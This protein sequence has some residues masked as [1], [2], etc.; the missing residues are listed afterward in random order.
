MA[1][2]K[3]YKC[4]ICGKTFVVDE[5]DREFMNILTGEVD[6]ESRESK[7]YNDICPDCYNAIKK[8]IDDPDI[9][10][11]MYN[12]IQ[13]KFDHENEHLEKM[14]IKASNRLDI[15]MVI[16]NRIKTVMDN[17]GCWRHVSIWNWDEN[18]KDIICSWINEIENKYTE[19]EMSCR[20][21]RTASIILSSI[22]V[23]L[24]ISII[25]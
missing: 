8:V 14:A 19:M 16:E 5:N 10:Q 1:E 18:A 20:G 7:A 17:L 9:I 3:T 11:K 4:D 13:A 25:I 21:W 24:M 2:V 23:G 6:K 12:E 15:L 22:V